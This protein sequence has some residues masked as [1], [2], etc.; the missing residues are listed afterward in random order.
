M[1]II[2]KKMVTFA[3]KD[4]LDDKVDNL[5]P[6][7]SK[8]T[9]QDSNNIKP[10]KPKTYQGKRRGKT[11]IIMIRV[12]IRIETDHIVEIGECHLGVEV[13]A[14]RF[15]EEDCNMLKIIEITLGEEILEESKIIEVII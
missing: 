12:I 15:I 9:A 8:L 2:D 7:M 6:M 11:R 14:D 3:M 5:P 13:N 4:R 1:G 10:F